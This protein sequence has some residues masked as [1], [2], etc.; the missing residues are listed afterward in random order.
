MPRS[1]SLT[2]IRVCVQS[3]RSLT[4][5]SV[6]SSRRTPYDSGGILPFKVLTSGFHPRNH[7]CSQGPLR[8]EGDG[9]VSCLRRAVAFTIG[10]D[11]EAH[12][13]IAGTLATPLGIYFPPFLSLLTVPVIT[14]ASMKY[15]PNVAFCKYPFSYCPLVGNINCVPHAG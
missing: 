3:S 15:L 8:I 14:L 11:M 1:T 2:R 6:D 10:K 5:G 13:P 9:C 4:G 7:E 12:L